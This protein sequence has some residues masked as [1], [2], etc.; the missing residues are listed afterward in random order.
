LRRF[1]F[2]PPYPSST[3]PSTGI[4]YSVLYSRPGGVFFMFFCTVDLRV[5]PFP[6]RRTFFFF[7]FLSLV[8]SRRGSL[9]SELSDLFFGVAWWSR[10]F[11]SPSRSSHPFLIVFGCVLV[12]CNLFLVFFQLLDFCFLLEP[13]VLSFGDGYQVSSAQVGCSPPLSLGEPSK[14][15]ALDLFSIFICLF[16]HARLLFF[17]FLVFFGCPLPLIFF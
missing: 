14:F 17:F 11:F 1:P 9:V 8:R 2:F 13:P 12:T 16:L 3:R 10:G 15:L 4:D 7:R 5:L 6:V